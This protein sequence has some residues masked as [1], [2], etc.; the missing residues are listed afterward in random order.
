VTIQISDDLLT[1]KILLV[2]IP[3]TSYSENIM[4]LAMQL[5]N[6]YARIAYISLNKLITPLKRSMQDKGIDTK[7]I[8]FIDGITKTAIP[9]PPEDANSIFLPAPND[10]TKLGI[11]MT[12][13][14][15]SYDPDVLIFDS[16]STLLIYED[17]NIVTQFVYS[18]I[19]KVH[20]YG[21]K[22]V[23]TCLDGEKEKQLI[24]NMSLIVDKIVR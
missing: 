2:V 8:Y 9:N 21:I 13:V 4:D 23:F 5:N 15:Q 17:P 12:K 20:A 7:K 14:M 11:A 3:N 22:V 6:N 10:L 24:N 1:K 19:N 18:I 16:L